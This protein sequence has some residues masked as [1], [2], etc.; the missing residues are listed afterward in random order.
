MRV[1]GIENLD[2]ETRS[3]TEPLEVFIGLVY[4]QVGLM[5]TSKMTS[6]PG[7][8]TRDYFGD[9]NAKFT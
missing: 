9:I 3:S 1:V 7:I 2:S 4:Q 6:A 8:R 5:S